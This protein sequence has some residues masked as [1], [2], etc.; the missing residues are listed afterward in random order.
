MKKKT[1]GWREYV[2]FP[3]LGIE[4]VIAKV[5]SGA[6]TSA[7]HTF[8]IEP[9]TGQ[10]GREWVRFGLH[11]V[12]KKQTPEVIAQA[13]VK[14][15]RNVSDSGGHIEARF[16]IETEFVVG[17]T[18]FMAE[19]TLTNREKMAYRMLLGRTALREHFVVDCDLSYAQQKPVVQDS[20]NQE[21][22]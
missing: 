17:D 8:F 10:D 19:L 3:D 2:A 11:P 18:R 6:K 16:V 4:Q 5:D 9:F 22:K 15:V 14:E 12:R 20:L 1:V 21:E 7:L 13:P